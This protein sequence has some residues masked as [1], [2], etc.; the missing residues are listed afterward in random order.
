VSKWKK[1]FL[2]SLLPLKGDLAD[3]LVRCLARAAADAIARGN[4]GGMDVAMQGDA[5][6]KVNG[7][8]ALSSESL[9]RT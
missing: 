7:P 5:G 1:P 4:T 3:G 9:P 6:R 8:K 2:I